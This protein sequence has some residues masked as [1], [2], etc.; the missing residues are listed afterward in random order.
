MYFVKTI[1][2]NKPD[3]VNEF[4]TELEAFKFAGDV[5]QSSRFNKAIVGMHNVF[6]PD[7]ILATIISYNEIK[8]K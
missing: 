6:E 7:Y 2:E 8:F 1:E 4:E 5:L 3:V